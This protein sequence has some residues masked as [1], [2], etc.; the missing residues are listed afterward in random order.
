MKIMLINDSKAMRVYL[1]GVIKSYIDCEMVGSYSNGKDALD[2]LNYKKPDVIILDLEMPHMDGLTFLEKL[3]GNKKIPTII[4][5]NYV[6]DGS[7]LLKDAMILG[8]VDSI[9]P[10]PSNTKET[11]KKFRNILHHKIIKASLKSNK[12]CLKCT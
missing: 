8:A 5:S 4:I 7:K 6:K 11:I 3:Q 12:F 9:A 1:D 2:S 10:P